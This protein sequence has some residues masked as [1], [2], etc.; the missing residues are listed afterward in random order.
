M[1][2]KIREAELEWVSLIVVVGEKEKKSNE[3]PVRIRETGKIEKMSKNELI[4]YV[5]ERIENYPFIKLSLPRC[6]TLR[7]KFVG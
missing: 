6:L 7:P 1:D 3:L 4:K 5:K 2:K